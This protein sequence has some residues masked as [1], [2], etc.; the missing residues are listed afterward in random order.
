M[1]VRARAAYEP[2]EMPMSKW[3][4]GAIISAIKD[5]CDD[6]DLAYDPKIESMTRAQLLIP[7]SNISPGTIRDGSHAG[8]SFSDWMRM[9]SAQ[10]SPRWDQI[11]LPSAMR[12]E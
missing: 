10:T 12:L 8:P 9:R 6:F 2:S 11:K 4:R 3:T 5:Y 7:I 1:S